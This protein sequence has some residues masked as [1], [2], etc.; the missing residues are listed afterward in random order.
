MVEEE[1]RQRF[2]KLREAKEVD[3]PLLLK[4]ELSTCKHDT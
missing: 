3:I 2:S 1:A 4:T